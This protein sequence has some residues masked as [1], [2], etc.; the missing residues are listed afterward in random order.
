MDLMMYNMMTI[1]D[2]T[3][4]LS[5]KLAKRVELKCLHQKKKKDKYVR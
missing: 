1:V 3:V 2:N 5:L 4:F